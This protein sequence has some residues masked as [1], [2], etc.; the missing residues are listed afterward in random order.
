MN[1]N[2]NPN[3]KRPVLEKFV[4]LVVISLAIYMLTTSF[5][6]YM[7]FKLYWDPSDLPWYLLYG[8]TEDGP[9]IV[10]FIIQFSDVIP[11]SLIMAIEA[12]K[13]H[14]GFWIAWDVEMYH[15]ETD[16]P[17]VAN[18]SNILDDLGQIGYVFTDK[19]GTLTD[20]IMKFRRLF[21]AGQ[22]WWHQDQR[23]TAEENVAPMPGDLTTQDL[24]A[25][26][27]QDPKSPLSKAAFEYILALAVC[28][29]CLP[30]YDSLGNIT[31]F[32]ASSPDELAL[33]RAAQEMGIL[34][35]RRSTTSLTLDISARFDGRARK[36][37]YEVLDVIEFSS[38]RKRMSIIV[39]RPDGR[40]WLVCKGADSVILP[41]LTVSKPEKQTQSGT[42][43]KR[44][45]TRLSFQSGGRRSGDFQDVDAP[46]VLPGPSH[47]DL[48]ATEPYGKSDE[49]MLLGQCCDYI[50][51]YAR[52]GLRT[53]LVVQRYLSES[54]YQSWKRRYR[55]AQV[56]LIDRQK[57]LEEIGEKLEHGFDLVGAT[58][59]EDKL[60]KGVPET[61]D[62]LRR[63]N[64]KIWMLTGDKRETAI[65]I[66]GIPKCAPSSWRTA[67][68]SS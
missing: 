7:G 65:N 20:N 41:L 35:A 17:A 52:E 64:I 53:L 40:L 59:V 19:T 12:I 61:I 46:G 50:D 30:E 11:M 21:V 55:E 48:R 51:S 4:D 27:R 62:R 47:F 25:R 5:L 49:A 31:D 13:L 39:R 14:L 6:L 15:K 60:Q 38:K 10:G 2:K 45:S 3:M 26:I 66:V 37:T 9:I 29:T 16:C 8:N 33:V 63:A 18:T 67:N 57:K 54:E 34:V 68:R 56:S 36:E 22:S 32:Q 1:A 28:H 42:Q 43:R 23:S 24:V 58:G 44:G